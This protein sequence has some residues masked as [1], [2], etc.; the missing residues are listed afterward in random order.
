MIS[1]LV[2][3][4]RS[5]ELAIGAIRSARVAAAKPLQ[6]VV[7]DNS[8][9]ASEA[10]SLRPHADL[11]IVSSKNSGYAAAINAGRARCEGS[12][13]VA[14]NPDVVFGD[15]AIDILAAALEDD[16]VA[17][18]G[19][20]LYWD[21][22]HEWILPPSDLPSARE[23]LDEALASRSRAWFSWRGRR[24]IRRR[25]RFWSLTNSTPVEAISGAVMAISAS[26][27]DAA[28]GFDERFRL[29]FEESDFLRRVRAR[30]K[31]ILYVPQARC[32]HLYNQSAGRST[33]AGALYAQSELRYFEKW[34]GP[35]FARMLI[36]LAGE[37]EL[38]EAA[39]L[40]GPLPIPDRDVVIE[41]SPLRSFATAA[42]YFPR[43]D[44]VTLPD[45]V[46][47]SYRGKVVYLRVVRRAD[48]RPLASYAKYK[49]D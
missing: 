2:V 26:E 38:E 16:R 33:D 9:D 32:R 25:L 11:L 20:A 31:R 3:N 8:V 15:R 24:R 1:L 6:V 7:V 30:N 22:A 21:D 28:G 45:E 18:A 27:F 42:G 37:P 43:N 23:K 44:S 19:P 17:V 35:A 39:P 13:I 49:S 48:G 47:R 41:A 5:A 10:E 14:S 40:P 4:Y 29:Y 12:I 46:W 36:N 34:N